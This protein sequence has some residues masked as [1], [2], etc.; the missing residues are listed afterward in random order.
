MDYGSAVLTSSATG[1]SPTSKQSCFNGSS[2]QIRGEVI[3]IL[4][5][6]EEVGVNDIM[7]RM[8][9]VVELSELERI[10]DGLV[11]DGL[12]EQTVSGD[13]RISA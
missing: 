7:S 9:C 6:S 1:I 13:F 11:S 2:L 12:A 8:D 3:R 5:H 10:I 4:T